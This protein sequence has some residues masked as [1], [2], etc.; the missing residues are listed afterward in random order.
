MAMTK[1]ES[2]ALDDLREEL[3]LAKALR[4]P[5]TPEPARDSLPERGY[6]GGWDFNVYNGRVDEMWTGPVSHGWGKVPD[7]WHPSGSRDGLR[8]YA[9]RLDALVALR[10]AKTREVAKVLADID[11]LIEAERSNRR[12]EP[13]SKRDDRIVLEAHNRLLALI[14]R[15]LEADKEGVDEFERDA[16]T[17]AFRVDMSS[18]Y[19]CYVPFTITVAP[20]RG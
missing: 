8:L 3:R 13:M 19:A 18:P 20:A 17:G 16:G 5:D 2:K 14:E 15:A 11:A 7:T 4:W 12:R 6:V 1:K 9:T 10:A